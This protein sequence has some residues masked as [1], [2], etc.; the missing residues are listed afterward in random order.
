MAT[1]L[2]DLALRLYAQTSELKK[3][4]KEAGNSAKGLQNETLMVGKKVSK[5]FKGM[6]KDAGGALR[7]MTGGLGA[8]GP[9]TN[10]AVG[11]LQALAVGARSLNAA[12]GPIG[13]IIAAIVIV[14]KALMAYFKGSSEGAQ[15]L[16]SIMGK[17][18]GIASF[19]KD[20]FIRLGEIIVNAFENPKEAV[21][22][23][24]EFIKQ[25]LVN[26][27]QGMIDF[28]VAAFQVLKNGF[29][30]LGQAIKGIFNDEARAEAQKYFQQMGTEMAN[31][32]KAA[33]AMATGLDVEKVIEAAGDAMEKL[34]EQTTEGGRIAALNWKIQQDTRSLLVEESSI[35][36]NMAD[37]LLKTR[38]YENASN[39]E[40]ADAL[41]ELVKQEEYLGQKKISLAEDALELAERQLANSRDDEAGKD[42]VAKAQAD[43]NNIYK[44]SDDKMREL[45]N[46]QNEMRTSTEKY[47]KAGLIG[48]EQMSRVEADA[49][50]ELMKLTEAAG[51]Y[52]DEIIKANEAA[53]NDLTFSGRLKNLE[54]ALAEEMRM[55]E[56]RSKDELG[57]ALLTAQQ[58]TDA[59]L[60]V[61][62]QYN[63]DKLALEKTNSEE[64]LALNKENADKLAEL[65]D[66]IAG[67]YTNS[68]AERLAALKANLD[69]GYATQLEYE[70]A[71]SA[72][73]MEKAQQTA[74]FANSLTD[75]MSDVFSAAKN[76][77]LKA[78]GDNEKKKEEILKKYAKR[79]KAIAISKAIIGTALAIVN[80]LQT[81]PFL[82]MGPIM[83]AVAGI[84]GAAQIAAIASTPLAQGGI[85]F[86]P[87][88]GLVGEYPGARTNPEVIAPL[89]K[90]QNMISGSNMAGKTQT[91]R[92]I[93]EDL[94]AVIDN[95]HAKLETY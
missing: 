47:V 49:A 26:R 20:A 12:L 41:D 60:A 35:R 77:E 42:A 29:Q 54:N 78:A 63:R 9:A 90:L 37:L 34:N 91:F 62:A 5:N 16:A 10:G 89:D 38:D 17:L 22:A 75:I 68:Y 73:K 80:A 45:V 56:E 92:I 48:W 76:R 43:L 32:G 25:N 83:A 30:G 57:N 53:Q 88:L 58:I 18:Q 21:A 55:I 72:M 79:E 40:R 6:S 84:A 85:A 82:P 28:F 39:K 7:Q 46:R 94:V 2:T 81:Q 15:K 31:V 65:N 3:G 33:V 14:V 23:L 93:G 27:F 70:E 71:V 61:E 36:R 24:W 1:I 50:L 4:L 44:E 59:K 51:D 8:L 11:G 67:D 87:T 86:G 64:I 52:V 95:V 69:A 66:S 74:D 19:L 13:L